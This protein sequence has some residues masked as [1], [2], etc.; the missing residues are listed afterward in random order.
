M[1]APVHVYYV[2]SDFYQNHK[3]YVRSVDYNQLHGED[4][5]AGSLGNCVP[6]RYVGS[7]PKPSLNNSG[8]MN[9]C[10]LT[11]WSLFN[12]SFTDFE[13]RPEVAALAAG[14]AR[15]ALTTCIWYSSAYVSGALAILIR[16]LAALLR[17]S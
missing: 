1:D 8:L 16:Q 15:V 14:S 13:V 3:R 9:P 12:D 2:L 6:Q 4:A 5:S 11:A 10:G 7:E 17:P